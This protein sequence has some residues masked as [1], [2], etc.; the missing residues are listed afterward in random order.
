MQVKTKMLVPHEIADEPIGREYGP[1]F[2]YEH[3]RVAELYPRIKFTK[4]IHHGRTG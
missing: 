1:D 3:N 2:H 4:R